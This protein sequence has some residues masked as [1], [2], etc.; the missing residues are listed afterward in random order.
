MTDTAALVWFG[1]TDSAER[2][3]ALAY[4][5]CKMC[6]HDFNFTSKILNSLFHEKN[7]S[8]LKMVLHMGWYTKMVQQK[9]QN[10]VMTMKGTFIDY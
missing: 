6:A 8:L 5:V 4:L 3:S 9:P 10:K 7:Y 2:C 1:V